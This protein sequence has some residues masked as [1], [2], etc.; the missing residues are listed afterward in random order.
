MRP[1][2]SRQHPRLRSGVAVALEFG[3][4]RTFAAE[5]CQHLFQVKAEPF[6]LPIKFI[7]LMRA[8]LLHFSMEL[9]KRTARRVGK[10]TAHSA[11]EEKTKRLPSR[12]RSGT[13]TTV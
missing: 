12:A 7:D 11:S 8:V 2:F 6:G 9:L 3:V 5:G 4:G 13:A 1:R 10:K